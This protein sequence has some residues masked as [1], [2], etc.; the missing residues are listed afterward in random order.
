M[1]FRLRRGRALEPEP[2]PFGLLRQRVVESAIGWMQVDRRAG[3]FVNRGHAHDVVQMGMGEPDRVQRPGPGV[4]L[5]QKEPGL[6][7]R[8]RLR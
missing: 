1:P 5:G 3:C 6:F 8:M 4:E 2:E 7:A